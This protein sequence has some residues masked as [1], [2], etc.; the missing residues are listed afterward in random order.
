MLWGGQMVW[1][2]NEPNHQSGTLTCVKACCIW[3]DTSSAPTGGASRPTAVKTEQSH[4]V[5]VTPR[6]LEV[7]VPP[8]KNM[9]SRPSSIWIK[10]E[11]KT[12]QLCS[13][14]WW[15]GANQSSASVSKFP[16][17]S[18]DSRRSADCRAHLLLFPIKSLKR[19]EIKKKKKKMEFLF[20]TEMKLFSSSC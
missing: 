4:W 14:D 20:S 5:P 13:P 19:R 16:Q 1:I 17:V 8:G 3:W 7:Q 2:A 11:E 15:P 9:G 10:I 6:L 12:F 18:E